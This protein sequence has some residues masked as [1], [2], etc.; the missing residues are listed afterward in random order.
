MDLLWADE[1]GLVVDG[2]TELTE[3]LMRGHAGTRGGMGRKR[4]RDWCSTTKGVD[5]CLQEGHI[6]LS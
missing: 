4:E 3:T 2:P 5:I 1:D 6:P